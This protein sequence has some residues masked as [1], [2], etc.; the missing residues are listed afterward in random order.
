MD[1]AVLINIPLKDNLS[2]DPKLKRLT[3]LARSAYSEARG[4]PGTA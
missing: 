1:R 2:H 3:R 4:A